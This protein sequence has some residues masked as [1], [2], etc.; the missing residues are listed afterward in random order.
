MTI[1]TPHPMMQ[2]AGGFLGKAFLQWLQELVARVPERMKPTE[3]QD[4]AYTAV[5]WDYVLCDPSGGAFAVTL[6]KASENPNAEI[7]VKNVTS[8]T[9]EITI[10]PATGETIDGSSTQIIASAYTSITM[11]A[12]TD[13]AEWAIE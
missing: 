3:V 2:V 11:L 1:Q 5:P 8:S 6:P 7:G 9:N 12:L 4:E 13:R 10:T